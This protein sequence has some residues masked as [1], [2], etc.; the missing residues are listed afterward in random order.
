VQKHSSICDVHTGVKADSSKLATLL[1]SPTC[2]IGIVLWQDP[3]DYLLI[4][5][6]LCTRMIKNALRCCFFSIILIAC[7]MQ[8]WEYY[9]SIKRIYWLGYENLVWIFSH[10]INTCVTS[11]KSPPILKYWT[12]AHIRFIYFIFVKYLFHVCLMLFQ[13]SL[14]NYVNMM[15]S[16]VWIYTCSLVS[17]F[18]SCRCSAIDWTWLYSCQR[19]YL[20]FLYSSKRS[21]FILESPL[22]ARL[23]TNWHTPCSRYCAKTYLHSVMPR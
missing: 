22:H 6:F 9:V 5:Y 21:L 3:P 4:I 23:C 10:K 17:H 13:Q 14:Y 1:T 11:L 15:F 8:M 2:I 19:H 20:G 12:Q 18:L 16:Q 7:F